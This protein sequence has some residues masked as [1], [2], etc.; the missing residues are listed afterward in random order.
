MVDRTQA[1]TLGDT[2]HRR[3]EP[4]AVARTFEPIDEDR[5]EALLREL[6]GLQPGSVR[7]QLVRER[8]IDLALP[9]AFRLAAR[10]RHRGEMDEDLRQVAAVGLVNAVDRYRPGAGRGFLAYAVPTVVGSLRHHL[11]DHVW[12]M[13]PPRGIL[14]LRRRVT[15]AEDELIQRLHREPADAEL[16]AQLG[17]RTVDVLAVRQSAR[18]GHFTSTES[19]APDNPR[20]ADP[21]DGFEAADNALVLRAALDRLPARLREIVRLRF[22]EGRTQSEIGAVLGLSQMHVSRLLAR[23]LHLLHDGLTSPANA[24]GNPARPGQTGPSARAARPGRCH[25]RGRDS[26]RFAQEVLS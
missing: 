17:L 20:F 3:R 25:S 19:L 15:T 5:V 26:P 23:A 9:F 4:A 16:A 13:R 12:S 24:G 6:D 14:E 22:W 1:A 8:I 2:G 10:Y 21:W 18:S 11:R 7:Y